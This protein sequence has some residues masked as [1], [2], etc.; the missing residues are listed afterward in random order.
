VMIRILP[1]LN[2]HETAIN[3]FNLSVPAGHD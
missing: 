1:G 3:L 2:T